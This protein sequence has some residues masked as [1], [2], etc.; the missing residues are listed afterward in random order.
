MTLYEALQF[1]KRY[2]WLF[3]FSTVLSVGL[4][5]ILLWF[6]ITPI[7]RAQTSLI[8]LKSSPGGVSTLL[9][10]LEGSLDMLGSLQNL[11]IQANRSVEE[12]LMSVLKSRSLTE[13]VQSE[14]SLR[15]LPEFAKELRLSSAQEERLSASEK[16]RYYRHQVTELLFERVTILPPDTRNHT[17]R[18]R[19][20]LSDPERSATLANTYVKHLYDFMEGILHREEKE[21][22]AYLQAQTETLQKELT[23]AEDALL[24]FQ[25]RHQTVVL[26]EEVKQRIKALSELEAEVLTAEAAYKDVLAR[27]RSLKHSA[28]E[29]APES[30]ATRNALDLELAG[31]RERQRILKQAQRAYEASLKSL[32]VQGLELARLQRQV[33]LKNQLFVLLKQQTQATQLDQQRQFKPFR[34]LDV[35]E[36]PFEPV[37]PFKPLW[38]AIS[39]ILGFGLALVLSLFHYNYRPSS[40]VL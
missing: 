15:D 37:H 29:L 21:Q 38:L 9:R 13:A 7:Y 12:D 34:V 28:A 32:P 17:L 26:E 2:R 6:V 40:P 24:M 33:S 18:I 35:A 19:A 22:L 8:L 25:Q 23:A 14:L 11:G 30:T 5:A 3:V 27:Q 4:S 10:Q 1:L 36:V 39:A 31:L 20:E 16:E